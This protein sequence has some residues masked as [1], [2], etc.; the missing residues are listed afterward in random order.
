MLKYAENVEKD[1]FM[2]R[3]ST[4]LIRFSLINTL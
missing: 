4:Q 2:Q 1:I 3:H